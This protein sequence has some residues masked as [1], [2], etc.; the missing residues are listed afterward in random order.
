[1]VRAQTREI[2]EPAM[3]QPS[4]PAWAANLL[5]VGLNYYAGIVENAEDLLESHKVATQS[6]FGTRSSTKKSDPQNTEHDKENREEPDVSLGSASEH[7]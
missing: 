5:P 6:S 1:M 4:K 3:S 7:T 2:K